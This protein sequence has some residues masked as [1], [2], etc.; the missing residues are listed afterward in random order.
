VQQYRPALNAL[1]NM[2]NL[3]VLQ[4]EITKAQ[5]MYARALSGLSNGLSQ[6]SERCI[7]LAAK[8]DALP[9][10]S[11]QREGQSKLLTVVERSAP[12][13]NRTKKS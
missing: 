2:G 10:P 6:S 11:R 7:K 13:H 8:I 3:Y 12:Q 1:E 5:A 4:A 9:S